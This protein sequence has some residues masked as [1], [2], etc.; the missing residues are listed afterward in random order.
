MQE[1]QQRSVYVD[2]DRSTTENICILP[3]T[4]DKV[5]AELL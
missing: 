3:T 2:V 5:P 4:G 1:H